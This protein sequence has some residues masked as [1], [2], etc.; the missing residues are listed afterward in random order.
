MFAKKYI[1]ICERDA[2]LISGIGNYSL[3]DTFEC[4]Q[5]FRHAAVSPSS[6]GSVNEVGRAYPGYVEYMTVIGK[7]VILVGQ[8]SEDELIFFDTD[9][10]LFEKTLKS[11]FSLDVDY[12]AIKEDI[13]SR[14][15]SEFLREA[16]NT[17]SIA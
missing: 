7:R 6:D 12:D 10:E 9:D 2:L 17:A 16:A 11:Y 13:L 15:N 3:K 1:N 8:R 4:G 5:C 14:T